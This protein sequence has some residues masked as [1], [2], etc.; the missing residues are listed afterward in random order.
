MMMMMMSL[1]GMARVLFVLHFTRNV[2]QNGCNVLLK[3]V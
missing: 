1:S 2:V 3:N